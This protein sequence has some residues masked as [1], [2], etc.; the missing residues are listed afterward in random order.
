MQRSRNDWR[1]YIQ[2]KMTRHSASTVLCR[3]VRQIAPGH[4]K[5]NRKLTKVVE[6]RRKRDSVVLEEAHPTSERKTMQVIHDT[7]ASLWTRCA[8]SYAKPMLWQELCQRPCCQASALATAQKVKHVF[9][10]EVLQ[11]RLKNCT[12]I[13]ATPA[14]QSV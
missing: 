9:L 7:W 12:P 2:L 5:F 10:T 1:A 4:W 13:P 6:S 14:A 11:A 8:N 3:V